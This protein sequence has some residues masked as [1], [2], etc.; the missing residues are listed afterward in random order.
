MFIRIRAI[1]KNRNIKQ[2][3]KQAKTNKTADV[4]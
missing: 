2:R 1:I 4:A 3:N